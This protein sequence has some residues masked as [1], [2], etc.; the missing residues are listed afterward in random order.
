MVMEMATL[1]RMK[2]SNFSSSTPMPAPTSRLRPGV[3]VRPSKT[4]LLVA[5]MTGL[6]LAAVT[7][8]VFFGVRVM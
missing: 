5:P 6:R 3:M 8:E 1:V 7:W 4:V 2:I